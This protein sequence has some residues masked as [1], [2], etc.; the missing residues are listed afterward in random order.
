MSTTWRARRCRLQNAHKPWIQMSDNI[1]VPSIAH[2]L[3]HESR[4]TRICNT[5]VRNT[6]ASPKATR[7][8]PS[9]AVLSCFSSKPAS[10]LPHILSPSVSHVSPDEATPFSH[11]QTFA[12]H[13]LLSSLTF[14]PVVQAD[15]SHPDEYDL[16][17]ETLQAANA[18]R[19]HVYSTYTQHVRQSTT[20][21]FSEKENRE[22]KSC[23][24]QKWGDT[25]S[26]RLPITVL[27]IGS[28]APSRA[29]VAWMLK[30]HFPL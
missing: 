29:P 19:Q 23:A 4:I 22:N 7:P 25:S 10:Q 15:T 5:H 20:S 18:Y 26:N 14:H 13:L 28:L 27:Q 9:H 17:C 6:K 11:T 24:L 3:T 21:P 8:I 12:K 1:H 30:Y 2:I 16:A